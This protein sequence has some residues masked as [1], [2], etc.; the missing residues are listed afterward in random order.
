M[1]KSKNDMIKRLKND[2]N[3]IIFITRHN[4][5][6]GGYQVGVERN[7]CFIQSNAIRLQNFDGKQPWIYLN[8]I[9]VKNNVLKYKHHDIVIDLK[10]K[11]E[12]V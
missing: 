1:I 8:E 11:E 5:N 6:N 10:I 12:E 3:S 9:D 7:C 4:H 2:I